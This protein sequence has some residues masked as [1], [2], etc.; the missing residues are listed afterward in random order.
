MV[1]RIE[2][3]FGSVELQQ[4]DITT[5]CKN[6]YRAHLATTGVA[7]EFSYSRDVPTGNYL[8]IQ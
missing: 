5:H 8:V 7:E 1:S 6:P 4:P 3:I 2:Q